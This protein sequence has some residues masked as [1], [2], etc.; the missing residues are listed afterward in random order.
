MKV[1]DLIAL[2]QALPQD[3]QVLAWNP[4]A[5]HDTLVINAVHKYDAVF[6]QSSNIRPE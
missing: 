5:E 6:I 1:K 4:D 2:L 3:A